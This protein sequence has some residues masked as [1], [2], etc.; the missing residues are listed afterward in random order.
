[1][2]MFR[3]PV[4]LARQGDRVGICVASLDAKLVERGI[5][6]TPNSVPLLSTVVCL[7]RKVRF[8]RF[9]C[10][11]NSKF[12]ITIGHTTINATV[13]FF[14]IKEIKEQMIKNEEKTE[15][16]C[17]TSK[18]S[19]SSCYSSKFPPLDFSWDADFEYQEEL[20]GAHVGDL[21]YGNEPVQWALL[22]FQQPVYCPMGSLIIGSRLETL[23]ATDRAGGGGQHCRLSFY[24]PIISHMPQPK[25]NITAGKGIKPHPLQPLRLY[26][27]KE[28]E[29]TVHR[30]VDVRG[31]LCFEAIGHNLYSKS[32][33]NSITAY[34]GMILAN[35]EGQLIGYIHKAF[36]STNKFRIRFPNGAA[37]IEAG[38]TLFLKF[39]RYVHDCRKLMQQT[40]MA[41]EEASESETKL[42]HDTFPHNSSSDSAE[43]SDDDA[44]VRDNSENHPERP[45]EDQ[46]ASPAKSLPRSVG[47][48][49][50]SQSSN[51]TVSISKTTEPKSKESKD[52]DSKEAVHQ[53]GLPKNDFKRGNKEDCEPSKTILTKPKKP[54]DTAPLD[55]SSIGQKRITPKARPDPS[56]SGPKMKPGQQQH[57]MSHLLATSPYSRPDHAREA[58]PPAA[59]TTKQH[60][61][62][63][64]SFDRD[65]PKKHYPQLEQPKSK[66]A[67]VSPVSILKYDYSTPSE[68]HAQSQKQQRH[69]LQ[70]DTA[71]VNTKSNNDIARIGKIESIKQT[72]EGEYVAIV[73]GAFRM[74]ENIRAFSGSSASGEAGQEGVLLGPF[75]KMGKCKVKFFHS[76]KSPSALPKAKSSVTITLNPI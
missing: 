1:M 39:K 7:V 66:H 21:V 26:R 62:A 47:I 61:S 57:F 40:G 29:C 30:V 34:L 69:V 3:K 49:L 64:H 44:H 10:K 37:N 31:D 4:K 25:L 74:E 32:A 46:L 72:P 50:P 20:V 63:G 36:G 16:S 76:D 23:D 55:L 45:P 5:A 24:G 75:A 2:Q 65:A 68:H 14:G 41:L 53:K 67:G 56:E 6:T 28:K 18:A 52:V 38:T 59:V 9:P 33:A 51:K 22:Q 70:G 12:H 35:E 48:S 19:L 11:S 13:T 42:Y 58:P 15:V 71:L 73:V 43:D 8:F 27:W 60:D 54:S 17:E